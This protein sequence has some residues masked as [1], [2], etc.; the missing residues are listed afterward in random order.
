M[1]SAVCMGLKEPQPNTYTPI[2]F[3]F[4]V[5]IVTRQGILLHDYCSVYVLFLLGVSRGWGRECVSVNVCV[6]VCVCVCV[7]MCV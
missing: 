2:S 1:L 3:S 6:C 4:Q 5:Q 7:S